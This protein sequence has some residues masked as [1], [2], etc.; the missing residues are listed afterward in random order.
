MQVETAPKADKVGKDGRVPVSFFYGLIIYMYLEDEMVPP[1]IHVQYLDQEAC[2]DFDGNLLEG[3]IDRYA[4][5]L[6]AAWCLIHCNELDANWK[7]CLQN[8]MP[9]QI[10]PLR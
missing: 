8:L 7:L 5:L 9:F 6:A 2:L 1:H 4:Q 10:D 3:E